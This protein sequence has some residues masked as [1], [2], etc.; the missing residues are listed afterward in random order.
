MLYHSIIQNT[1]QKTKDL[2]NHR[3]TEG[4]LGCKGTQF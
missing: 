2:E 3:K 4:E 1:I